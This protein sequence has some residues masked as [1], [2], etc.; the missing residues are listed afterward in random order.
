MVRSPSERSVRVAVAVVAAG[1][2]L[3][4][5]ALAVATR[6]D[7]AA[8]V[9][10]QA[11]RGTAFQATPTVPPPPGCDRVIVIGDSLMDNAGP[12][13]RAELADAGFEYF[14][15]AQPS[16]RIPARV[17]APYSGVRAALAARAGWGEAGCWVVA[18]GSNDL[19]WGGGDA[20]TARAMIDEMLAAVTPGARVWWVNVD[21]HRDPRTSFDFPQ[22][23]RVFNAELEARAAADPT[24]SV[25]D[26][27][28]HAEANLHWFFD[29]VHVDRTGSIARA[30]QTVAALP[31]PVP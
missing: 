15:D 27:Y 29:P 14:V 18:L 16:R 4:A 10:R 26:W 11:A 7:R 13:L 28:A 6:L 1:L 31:R 22:A 20:A 30:V 21:Y 2:L 23:S 5:V 25:I 12:W 17:A 3:P 8:T 9:D 19:Y 24:L